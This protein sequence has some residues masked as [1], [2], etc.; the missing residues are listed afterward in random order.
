MMRF[1]QRNSEQSSAS[2]VGLM[3]VIHEMDTVTPVSAKQSASSD[4]K[5]KKVKTKVRMRK[6]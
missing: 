4:S 1:T 3:P 2:S 6:K 5:S